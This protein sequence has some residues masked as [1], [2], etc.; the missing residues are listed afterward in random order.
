MTRFSSAP[1]SSNRLRTDGE[2]ASDG[3]LA[4]DAFDNSTS[5]RSIWLVPIR[6]LVAQTLGSAL[7]NKLEL[8]I[9]IFVVSRTSL[10]G[11][12]YRENL[13]S[14]SFSA[15][16]TMLPSSKTGTEDERLQPTP[17]RLEFRRS[18]GL[19]GNPGRQASTS[20]ER[21]QGKL[22]VCA[23]WMYCSKAAESL[24]GPA[25]PAMSLSPTQGRDCR[26]RRLLPSTPSGHLAVSIDPRTFAQEKST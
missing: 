4:P 3:F 21:R 13:L 11:T 12:V 7:G 19:C 15:G 1:Y 26:V 20:K 6:L 17:Q 18:S 16:F 24:H 9:L 2:S 5:M 22:A 25:L 23:I 10:V 8:A 14:P